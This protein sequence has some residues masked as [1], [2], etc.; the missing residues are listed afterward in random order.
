MKYICKACGKTHDDIPDI[1]S[2]RPVQ[3][4]EIPEMERET[5]VK[6]TSDTCTIDHDHYFIRG[7]IELP[8]IEMNDVFGWGVWISLKKENFVN[9]LLT[10]GNDDWDDMGPFFGWLCTKIDYYTN[11]TMFLKT[12]AHIRRNGLRPSIK[13]EPS[14]HPLSIHQQHGIP[15]N[16]V[17]DIIHIYGVNK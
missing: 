15:I 4:W 1:G 2:D 8:I 6:L 9:Y 7:V 3:Y 16:E 12:M 11:D 14:E 13:V 17:Y 10:F 5:R